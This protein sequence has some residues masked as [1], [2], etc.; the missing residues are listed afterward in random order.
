[1]PEWYLLPFYAILRAHSEQAWRR[2]AMF[3]AIAVFHG[4]LADTSKGSR[5]V[6]PLYNSSSGFSQPASASVARRAAAGGF[7]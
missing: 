2:I 7:M 6:S 5:R 3:G 1:V 4:A